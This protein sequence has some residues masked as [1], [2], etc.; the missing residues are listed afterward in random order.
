MKLDIAFVTQQN[1]QHRNDCGAACVSMLVSK[2]IEAVLADIKQPKDE[3]LHM[4]DILTSMRMAHLP[5]EHARPLHLPLLRQSLVQG[6][7]S[8]VLVNY[9]RLPK[10]L[11]AADYNKN[12]FV[13]VTGFTPEGFLV[14]DPL[15]PDAHGAW[16]A[17]PDS[18]LGEAMAMVSRAMPMQGVIVKRPFPVLEVNMGDVTPLVTDAVENTATAYLEQIYV[19]MGITD[20][21]REQRQGKALA[22]IARWRAGVR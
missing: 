19:V 14:H 13:V 7:P 16:Q 15:W 20:G 3:E 18:V 17:W 1:N 9:G 12:H 21:N 8:I 6:W 4:E 2:P 10:A 5:H 11:K 22:T